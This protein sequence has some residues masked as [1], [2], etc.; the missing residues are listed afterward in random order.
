[1]EG[2]ENLRICCPFCCLGFLKPSQLLTAIIIWDIACA[3]GWWI[4]NCTVLYKYSWAPHIINFIL[5]FFQ[6]CV[7][8]DLKKGLTKFNL[9]FGYLFF[10][11]ICAFLFTCG[12][13]AFFIMIF[14]FWANPVLEVS[15]GVGLWWSFWFV[16]IFFP[17]T[18]IIWG[19][20]WT[21]FKGIKA[22]KVFVYGDGS[23]EN[24]AGFGGS[25]ANQ[26]GPQASRAFKV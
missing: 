15:G 7:L 22:L 13:V 10:R 19:S 3:L 4:Y 16:V 9:A 6:C 14:V 21:Y 5:V 8:L 1:M 20:N 17:E 11:L 12:L 2:E 18:F 26:D 25:Y 24:D 23:D